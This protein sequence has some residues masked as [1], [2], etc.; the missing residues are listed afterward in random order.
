MKKIF[1]TTLICLMIGVAAQAQF[2]AEKH[3]HKLERKAFRLENRLHRAERRARHRR[4]QLTLCAPV[5]TRFASR[6]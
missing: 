1:L 3:R 5:I 6:D 4:H 2:R